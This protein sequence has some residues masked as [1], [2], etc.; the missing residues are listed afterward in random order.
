MNHR[1]FNGHFINQQLYIDI[2]LMNKLYPSNIYTNLTLI[3]VSL[4]Q[5]LGTISTSF[6]FY[7][8][9]FFGGLFSFFV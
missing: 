9:L 2:N 1:W 3:S 4:T 8:P 5:A 6:L 7:E